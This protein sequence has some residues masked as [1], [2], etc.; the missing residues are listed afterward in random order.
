MGAAFFAS[1]NKK[2]DALQSVSQAA[3]LAIRE[4]DAKALCD[5]ECSF[6]KYK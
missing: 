5:I 2:L 1:L 4:V 3:L 6:A